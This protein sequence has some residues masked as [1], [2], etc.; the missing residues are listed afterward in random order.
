M[1]IFEKLKIYK[2]LTNLIIFY[3]FVHNSKRD[4]KTKNNHNGRSNI[5]NN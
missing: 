5:N 3:K 4:I 1:Y 2:N